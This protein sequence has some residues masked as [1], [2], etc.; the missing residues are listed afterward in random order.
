MAADAIVFAAE[1][2]K[3]KQYWVGTS[4]ALTVLANR[5]AAP[6][7]DRYLARTGYRSQQTD[8]SA[9][10]A[11]AGNLWLPRDGS[12]GHDFGAHGDF[13]DR[14]HSTDPQLALSRHRGVAWSG[15]GATALGIL[16]WRGARAAF[17][18]TH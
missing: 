14:A 6:L 1:H 3:R 5:V 13:D 7:L 11:R 9:D 15:L 8:E 16:G 10:G 4:T 17:R 2:P 12:A 18:H